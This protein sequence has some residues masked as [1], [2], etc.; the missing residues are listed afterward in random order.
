MFWLSN[1]KF[2]EHV[3]ILYF[4]IENFKHVSVDHRIQFVVV[5]ENV[6]KKNLDS[7]TIPISIYPNQNSYICCF[8]V[9]NK[10]RLQKQK[11]SKQPRCGKAHTSP[12][13]ERPILRSN[14]MVSGVNNELADYSH[15][16]HCFWI[17]I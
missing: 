5:I 3:Q 7:R 4:K 16:I 11:R 17:T 12:I 1:L 2:F 8:Q 15:Q 9:K 13:K 14:K 10:S 6:E